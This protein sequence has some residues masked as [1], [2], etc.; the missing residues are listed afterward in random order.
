MIVLNN[1]ISYYN[2][3][4]GDIHQD[5]HYLK[6]H[7]YWHNFR[8]PTAG[9]FGYYIKGLC[10]H[11]KYLPRLIMLITVYT[12]KH[13]AKSHRVCGARGCKESHE[14]LT[15]HN[16]EHLYESKARK[17]GF[18]SRY[19][20]NTYPEYKTKGKAI[21]AYPICKYLQVQILL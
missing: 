9:L 16:R 2:D 6:L 12:T 17:S 19:T 15:G 14:Q 11:F 20:P 13:L 7:A 18:V 10:R 8:R 4:A 1:G 5:F 3:H 21:K